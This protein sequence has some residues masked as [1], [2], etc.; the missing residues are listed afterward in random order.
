MRKLSFAFCISLAFGFAQSTNNNEKKKIIFRGQPEIGDI[1]DS[2]SA[3]G[4]VADILDKSLKTYWK[5]EKPGD[6]IKVTFHEPQVLNKIDIFR[7]TSAWCMKNW[8]FG[9]FIQVSLNQSK[10]S[11]HILNL[12][13]RFCCTKM[14]D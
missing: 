6:F 3:Y 1:I 10:Y 11:Q 5:S 13:S 7:C 14:T 2:G 4:S 9:Y 12:F 8:T